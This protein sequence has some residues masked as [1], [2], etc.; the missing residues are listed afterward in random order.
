MAAQTQMSYKPQHW[1]RTTEVTERLLKSRAPSMFAELN[2]TTTVG[3]SETDLYSC[4]M[5]LI[6]GSLAVVQSGAADMSAE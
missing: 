1:Q 4:N 3:S 5:V 2:W 6:N